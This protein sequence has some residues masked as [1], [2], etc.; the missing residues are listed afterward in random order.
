MYIDFHSLINQYVVVYLDDVIVFSKNKGDHLAHLRFVLQRCRKYGISLN[1]KKYVFSLEQ[2]KLLGFIVSNEG[3]IIDLERTQVISKLPPPSSKKSMQSFLGQINFVRRFVPIFSEMVRPLQNLIKKDVQY[4]WGPIESQ[5]F[6]SIKKAIVDAP[7]LMSYDFLRDFTLYTFAYDWSY[8]VVLTQKNVEN[9]EVPIA[10]MSL[11]FKGEELNY[12]AVDQQ[13]YVV[14]NV[15]KHFRS[16]LLKSRKKIIVPYPV[17]RNLLV[18]KE[19]GEKRA[20]WVTSLQEYDIEITPA[21]IVRGQGLCKL[22]VNSAIGQQNETDMSLQDQH[23]QN[24]ICC[25]QNLTSPWYDDIKFYLIHRSAP[26]YLDPKKRRAL[27]LKSTSFQLVNGILFRQ[28][29]DGILMRCLEKDEADKVYW[30]YMQGKL[31][32]IL[33]ETPLPTKY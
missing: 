29:F 11:S 25:A 22:V 2:G 27:R 32:G 24:Q 15:V 7:S 26:R 13:A 28:N 30:N 8:V 12:P 19:L 5:S 6:D 4:H 20:N 31:V 17:V 33:V 14:F 16:Y 21:E 23:N 10:F 1:P 3:M 18:Q 9:N